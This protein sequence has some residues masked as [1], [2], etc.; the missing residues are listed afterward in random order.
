MHLKH[1][2]TTSD[3]LKLRHQSSDSESTKSDDNSRSS[4][5]SLD[6]SPPY[7]QR[8]SAHSRNGS[9]YK[10]NI[11][12]VRYFKDNYTSFVSF[13]K[14]CKLLMLPYYR[15]SHHMKWNQSTAIWLRTIYQN[16]GPEAVQI[17]N[18][19]ETVIPLKPW[20]K[21]KK[22]CSILKMMDRTV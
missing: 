5:L 13:S 2:S 16:K 9:I 1:N 10:N 6:E 12:M 15:L 7:S 17:E 18:S 19:K 20:M 21:T 4:R 14:L 11:G 22:E 3:V 8:K